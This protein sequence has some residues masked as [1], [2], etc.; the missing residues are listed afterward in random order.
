MSKWN[1]NKVIVLGHRGFSARYPE[2]TLLS[3]QKAIEAGADGVELDVWLSKDEHLVV[4]HDESIDRTSDM[5]GRQ[6]EMTISDLKKAN[7]GMGQK[8]PTLEEVF[9]ALPSD[10]LINVELKDI[11]AT[12]RTIDVIHE[13]GALERVMISSF[14]IETLKKVREIDKEIVLG[15][16]VSD[17]RVVSQVQKLVE[18]LNLYSINVPIEGVKFLGFE[19]F[20]DLLLLAKSLKLKVALWAGD[21]EFYYQDNNLKHLLGVYNI[22]IANDIEKIV[23]YL[24]S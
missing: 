6:K 21:D 19:K 12:R 24:R 16:L 9:K 1:K 13:F 15:L 17:E 20:M 4:I 11:D 5:K 14:S 18:E 3:F 2:N 10:T 22:V 7:L 23:K 8:I